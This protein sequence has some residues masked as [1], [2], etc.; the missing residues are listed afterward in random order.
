MEMTEN[1]D[2]PKLSYPCAYPIKVVGEHTDDFL[3]VIVAIVQQHD[4]QV[5]KEEV[6]V[7]PSSKGRYVSLHIV[8]TAQGP[9]HIAALHAD[10]RASGRVQ[11]V[12]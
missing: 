3:A 4:P 11:I 2:I 1:Q 5:K 12:L 7:R 6:R 9:D 10:L 8:F